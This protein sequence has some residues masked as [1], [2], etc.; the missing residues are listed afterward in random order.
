MRWLKFNIVGVMGAVVQA[1]A[2]WLLAQVMKVNYLTTTALAVEL[3]IVHNF[4]W[5]IHWT[6]SDRRLDRAQERELQRSSSP[7][8]QV[9]KA[10]VRF[11]LLAGVTSLPGNLVFTWL[12]VERMQLHLLAANLI[13][14]AACSTANFL[15]AD[16]FSFRHGASES[17][18]REPEHATLFGRYNKS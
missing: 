15:L 4:I 3:A 11:Q 1:S 5:H 12:L 7:A 8:L 18:Q 16:R 17:A 2:L 6:F 10:F 13:A 9:P 14:I